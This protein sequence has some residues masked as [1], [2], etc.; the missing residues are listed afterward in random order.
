MTT[1]GGHH[2]SPTHA[3][4]SG[5]GPVTVVVVFADGP[6][7]PPTLEVHGPLPTDV[8]AGLDSD[9]VSSVA[10]PHFTR[11]EAGGPARHVL[12]SSQ[13][14]SAISPRIDLLADQL[15]RVA[16]CLGSPLLA[17]EPHPGLLD[18]FA[19]TP[20]QRDI[21]AC[22]PLNPDQYVEQLCWRWRGP[23][24]T[25]RFTEAWQSVVDREALLRAA[26]VWDPHPKVAL[27]RHGVPDVVRHAH[28][29][30][31]SRAALMAYERGRGFDLR[32]PGLLRVA[33]LDGPPGTGEGG[34]S[35]DV[36]LT[37]HR[38]LFDHW[39]V[40]L[41][42]RGFYR[43]YRA[44]GGLRGGEHRP[45]LRDYARWLRPQDTSAARD[46][47]GREAAKPA[48]GLRPA[49]YGTVTG[50]SGTGRS[51]VQLTE[52]EA[53]RLTKWTAYQGTTE[54][55]AVYA[56]WAVL[57]YR[58]SAG[59]EGTPARVRFGVTVTG[60]GV[61]LEDIERAP[62]PFAH[63]LPVSV[64][65][66]PASSLSWLLRS[67]RDRV[68]DV[69][70]YEW[71]SAGQIHDW[72]E[73]S[74]HAPLAPD[75]L[76]VSEGT[77]TLVAFYPPPHGHEVD[78]PPSCGDVR[79]DCPELVAAPER[80]PLGVTVHHDPRGGLVLSSTYDRARVDDADAHAL[81]SRTADLLRAMPIEANESTSV[82]DLLAHLPGT[83]APRLYG[84]SESSV[85]TGPLVTLREAT[86]PGAAT[87]CHVVTPGQ[88]A[89]WAG[90]SLGAD[91]SFAVTALHPVPYGVDRCV[92]ALRQHLLATGGPVVFS[93]LSGVGA[94]ACEIAV[95]LV[96][97]D[98][99]VPPVVLGGTR[100]AA[101]E[102]AAIL[103]ASQILL[104]E[105][106]RTLKSD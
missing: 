21:F 75:P 91:A 32:R 22:P 10:L 1:D 20:R 88:P 5:P 73:Q 105:S 49:A 44:D 13:D 55:I 26:F 51:W 17:A 3:D 30:F 28:G 40:R 24:D 74:P 63:S 7:Q 100:A 72:L 95:R 102:H 92:G 8:V 47:W 59:N 97:L 16:T 87:I 106:R 58:A 85:R 41:L 46:F 4:E 39:S 37:Y 54:S 11:A 96:D 69:S 36:L 67:L 104:A 6:N 64:K 9:D 35:T 103:A 15:T 38:A 18:K 53:A 23:L 31:E 34:P 19:A 86:E 68:L 81:L 42:L 27:Y 62:G 99:G 50:R 57:L 71:V 65:V 33:L 29:A 60:R 89:S 52:E 101:D 82:S 93:G 48:E 94:L 77:E 84:P 45:D 76:P 14:G 25:G 90:D 61:F 78:L 79:A 2:S 98:G 12:R 83:D 66:D 56:A 80:T 43:A 70:T